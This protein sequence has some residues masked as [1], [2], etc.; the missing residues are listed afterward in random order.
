MV[1]WLTKGWIV[2]GRVLVADPK[3][4]R[5]E[6]KSKARRIVVRLNKTGEKL[7]FGLWSV[8]VRLLVLGSIEWGQAVSC[9]G[10]VRTGEERIVDMFGRQ[11]NNSS[12]SSS[13][14]QSIKRDLGLV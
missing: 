2:K 14:D 8:V 12:D 10:H 11:R 4:V 7:W 3:L 6:D 1:R 13:S 5:V 9:R